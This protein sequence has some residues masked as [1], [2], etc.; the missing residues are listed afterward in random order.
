MEKMSAVGMIITEMNKEYAEMPENTQIEKIL[1]RLT[2][3][4][5]VLHGMYDDFI[6]NKAMDE[7]IRIVKEV[8]DESETENSNGTE[9]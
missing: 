3:R 1:K 7:A 2:G 6:W 8:A 9:S 5:K 4:K